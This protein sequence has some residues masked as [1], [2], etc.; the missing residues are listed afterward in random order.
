MERNASWHKQ[1]H[2]KFNSS[3]LERDKL[4]F[5]R[6]RKPSEG[7]SEYTCR[8]KHHSTVVQNA[9]CIFCGG[10]KTID[11]L[12]EFTTFNVDR[13]I[14]DMAREMCDSELLVKISGV[15]DLVASEGKHHFTY[16]TKYRNRYR[17]F[18]RA[19]AGS[20]SASLDNQGKARAFAELVMHIENAMEQGMYKFKLM[21]LHMLP[22]KNV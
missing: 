21:E 7:V 14:K 17:A 18:Q 5:T 16:L 6:K 3:M 20:S 1:C 19:Q 12:H 15:V 2:Q 9:V 8:P 4:K 10:D 13:S 11:Q 22:M